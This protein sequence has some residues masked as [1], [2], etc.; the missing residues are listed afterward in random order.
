MISQALVKLFP[1]LT[2]DLSGRVSP[3]KA[4]SLQPEAVFPMPD[5]VGAMELASGVKPASGVVFGV[6]LKDKVG[7]APAFPV[8]EGTAEVGRP[9]AATGM[10]ASVGI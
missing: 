9:P 10:D 2:T 3:I 1:A 5:E 7:S 8:G 6:T 4:P